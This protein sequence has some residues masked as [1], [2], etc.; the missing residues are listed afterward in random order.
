VRRPGPLLLIAVISCTSVRVWAQEYPPV[1]DRDFAIDAY[2]G[3]TVASYRIVGMGGV[4]MATAEGAASM[5]SNPASVASRLSTW[6]DYFEWDFTVDI[7]TPALGSDYDNNGI[8]QA[9]GARTLAGNAGIMMYLGEWG[10]GASVVSEE[11]DFELDTKEPGQLATTLVRLSVGRSFLDQQLT[12][13]V[14]LAAGVFELTSGAEGTAQATL[15]EGTAAT[16]EAGA[17][18]RPALRDFRIGGRFQLPIDA[19][20]RAVDCDPLDCHGYILPE[21]VR[22]PWSAAAGVAYR[23]GPTPWNQRVHD[24]WR[25]E[26]ALVVAADLLVSGPVSN[27]YGTEAYLEHQLQPSGRDPVLSLRAGAEYEWVPGWIRVRA[28][29]YWEPGRFAGV[30]GRL[31]GTGGIDARFWSFCFWG[32]RYRLRASLALDTASGYSNVIGSLGF[33]H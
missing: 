31:H 13:G 16:L 3:S 29:S 2:Q 10:F 1:T 25:D 26:R 6:N 15:F 18:W 14:N 17:L 23:F 32:D 28:G 30:G 9:E 12:V 19:A 24:D 11:H 22:F 5:T 20:V 21:R 7:Y 27:G 8:E 33:W 4:A